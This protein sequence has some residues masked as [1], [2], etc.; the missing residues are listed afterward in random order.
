MKGRLK[1][2]VRTAWNTWSG[3]GSAEAGADFVEQVEAWTDG[4][5]A[6]LARATAL[7]PVRLSRDQMADRLRHHL[8]LIA[9]GER[10]SYTEALELARQKVIA[11]L[12][13]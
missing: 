11:E 9:G 10:V 3:E 2:D 8:G 7:H 4:T 5:A 13:R 12:R 1:M 6:Q